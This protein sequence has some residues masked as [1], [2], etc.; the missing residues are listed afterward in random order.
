MT[1]HGAAT[2]RNDGLSVSFEVRSVNGRHLKVSL[3][4]SDSL[5]SLS[6]KVEDEIR[7]RVHRGTL[8]AMLTIEREASEDDFRLE[9]AALRSY[10]RQL[11][12]IAAELGDQQMP[13][14]DAFL[15]LPGVVA[16]SSRREI[17]EEREWPL[18]RDTVIAALEQLHQMRAAEGRAMSADLVQN[19]EAIAKQL[20][21]IQAWAPEVV[22]RHKE[23]LE[24]RIA[25]LLGDDSAVA[26]E[27][28]VAREVAIFADR[29]DISEETVRL[30][31]HLEQFRSLLDS[32]ESQ[33][34]KLEFLLQ[35]MNREA[36]T[37]AAKA[38]DSR[39]SQAA[40]EIKA[41]LERM[42][43]MVQNVE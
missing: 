9:E 10:Y 31:S 20:A 15:S 16:E 37:T 21:Q 2:A 40:V 33:G 35:E 17:D 43:E 5:L 34:R 22:Q 24:Q 3:R 36:N 23:R 42:R 18:V 11:S 25:V 38:N 1:G 13:P 8:Y 39:I 4:T 19:I 30:E 29:C 12:E 6:A 41:A 26:G 7:R 27:N 28:E 14:I 32:P